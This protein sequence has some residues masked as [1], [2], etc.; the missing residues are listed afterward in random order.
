MS[1]ANLKVGLQGWIY[2]GVQGGGGGG[3]IFHDKAKIIRDK[4]RYSNLSNEKML[5]SQAKLKVGLQ[6]WIY[7]GVQGG[8]GGGGGGVFFL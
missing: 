8:G 2:W 1:Q 5:M 6:G 3:A 7:W 4:I